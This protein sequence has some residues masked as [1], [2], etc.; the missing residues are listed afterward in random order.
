MGAFSA[1][2]VYKFVTLLTKTFPEWDAYKKA[3]IDANGQIISRRDK[4]N[5]FENFVRKIKLVLIRF[6][7]PDNKAILAYTPMANAGERTEVVFTVPPPGD[8]SYICSYLGH[9][10]QMRGVLHSVK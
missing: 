4:L 1:Y 8:Y 5:V 3:I 2:N 10:I 9:Y 6:G 7:V